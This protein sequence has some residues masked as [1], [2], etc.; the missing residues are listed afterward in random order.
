MDVK[1]EWDFPRFEIKIS[2]GTP[3]LHK[4]PVAPFTNMV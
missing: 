1:N 4:T 2:D 3:I